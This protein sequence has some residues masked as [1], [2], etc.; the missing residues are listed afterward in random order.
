MIKEIVEIRILVLVR[1][2]SLTFLLQKISFLDVPGR[3]E[4]QSS[5]ICLN[6]L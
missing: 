4:V 5:A 3:S 2:N 6:P 1:S